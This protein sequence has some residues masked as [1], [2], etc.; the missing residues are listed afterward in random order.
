VGSDEPVRIPLA[1][2]RD[3]ADATDVVISFADLDEHRTRVD[4][5]H[6]GWERL[7]AGGQDWR[8]ANIGGWSSML[9][10]YLDYV[11]KE[12]PKENDHDR[13]QEPR[14]TRGS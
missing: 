5:E 13:R 9:P 8:D 7:G 11:T 14:T 4:I 1:P 2:A 6:T 12:R 10:Y 3:R